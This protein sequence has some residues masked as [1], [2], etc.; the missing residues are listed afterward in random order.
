MCVPLVGTDRTLGALTLAA[1]SS[2]RRYGPA[3]LALA[4]ELA[5]RAAVAVE[6]ASLYQAAQQATRARD[7][8]LAVVAHDLR[9]P[10]NTVLMAAELL[11]DVANGHQQV[12]PRHVEII[13]RAGQ[14]MDRMIQDL[15]DVQRMEAGRLGIDPKPESVAD[16]VGDT[17]EMLRPMAASSG[18]S[19]VKDV[20]EGLPLVRA[21]AARV[22]QVLS[23]LIGNALKFT[24]RDGS[25]TISAELAG[26][27]I[28]VAVIDTGAG[29]E[30]EQLPHIFGRFWQA[31]AGDRR[32][33]GLGLAIA[34][35]IVEEHGGRI[36]VESVPRKGSTF[37]F[38]LRKA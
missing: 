17:L 19:L 6:H 36:W 2:G 8:V 27:E 1:S 38:T 12:E 35:G 34:K 30:P 21:D 13:S 31:M 4:E 33:I 23:N 22:Q 3:D 26:E 11:Q 16:I 14:R 10:L 20:T 15:L 7:N 32:G 5:H 18:V 9:N 28:R 24:P 37:Y 29:I 25:V